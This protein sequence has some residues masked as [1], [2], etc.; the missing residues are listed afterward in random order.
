MTQQGL[1]GQL[2]R[3]RDLFEDPLFVRAGAGVAPT[4]RAES[5]YP[6][7]QGALE[8]L[9]A[10]LVPPTFDP[11]RF[12]GVISLATTDYALVLLLPK[13]LH[14]LRTEA[15][16]LRLA[17]RPVNSASLELEMRNRKIDLALT[18]PQFVPA[19]LHSRRL[20][21]ERYVGVVRQ[22]H[23]LA[24]GSIDVKRFVAFPHLLVSPDKG[25]FN[26]PTDVALDKIGLKRN[27]ALVVP[28]FSVVAAII[29]TTDLVAVLPSRLLGQTRRKLH[30]F[31]P[32]VAV[33]GFD[34]HAYWPE[35][36]NN[37]AMHKWFRQLILESLSSAD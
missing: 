32:P 34:L 31:E 1:S 25:D 6:L 5:L 26:G 21:R 28:S 12:I 11:A 33:E 29:D 13:L 16:H 15:P 36:L 7:V 23:P 10:L 35:R 9:R 18:I 14:R 24:K 19:G 3:L 37:D 8:K 4:P 20:F 17:V 22:K 30:S 27:I 2:S